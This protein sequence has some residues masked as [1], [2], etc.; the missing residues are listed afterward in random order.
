MAQQLQPAWPKNPGCAQAMRAPACPPAQ[1]E[2]Q[3]AARPRGGAVRNLWAQV[4]LQEHLQSQPALQH[5]SGHLNTS[6][7][8]SARNRAGPLISRA[9]YRRRA[10]LFLVHVTHMVRGP[11]ELELILCD[12]LQHCTLALYFP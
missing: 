4:W 11:L 7:P 2:E 1:A 5:W 3:K 8:C 9:R 10:V 12:V 6:V